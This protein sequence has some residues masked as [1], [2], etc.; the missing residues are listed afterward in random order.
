MALIHGSSRYMAA[1]VV[2]PPLVVVV[3]FERVFG[4]KLKSTKAGALLV[5]GRC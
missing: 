2:L 5:P 4:K 1:L 3:P